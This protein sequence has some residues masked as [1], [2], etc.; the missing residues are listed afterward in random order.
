M[1]NRPLRAN[2]ILASALGSSWNRRFRT[3]NSSA[4]SGSVITTRITTSSS[5]APCG[6]STAISTRPGRKLLR[7]GWIDDQRMLECALVLGAA[8]RET[9]RDHEDRA[10]SCCPQV[11][12]VR[13]VL[14]QIADDRGILDDDLAS[15][16]SE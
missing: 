10:Q 7:S 2:S 11:D 9:H 1:D 5:P 16:P 14:A 6:S 13:E 12:P 4:T 8:D 15:D 3:A